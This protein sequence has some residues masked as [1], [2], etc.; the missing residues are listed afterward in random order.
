MELKPIGRLQKLH[1]PIKDNMKL[2][3]KVEKPCRRNQ[4]SAAWCSAFRDI[5]DPT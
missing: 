5:L 3:T 4:E 1:A 2:Y